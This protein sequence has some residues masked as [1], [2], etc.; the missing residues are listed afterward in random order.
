ML[1]VSGFYPTTT[2]KYKKEQRKNVC[3]IFTFLQNFDFKEYLQFF[4]LCISA[5][6][7]HYIH[8]TIND[9]VW[10]GG[11]SLFSRLDNVWPLYHCV[12]IKA[13]SGNAETISAENLKKRRRLVMTINKQYIKN[14]F[15]TKH[16]KQ[17]EFATF[18]APIYGKALSPWILQ[19]YSQTAISWCKENDGHIQK[20]RRR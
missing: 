2:S 17:P 16:L 20:C 4:A 14:S 1:Q 8:W 12:V 13:D 6:N 10:N 5:E 15:M 9:V 18:Q 19:S 3:E 7:C 11:G